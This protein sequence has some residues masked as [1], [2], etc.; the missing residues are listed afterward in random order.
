MKNKEIRFQYR[1]MNQDSTKSKH[2]REFYYSGNN[3]RILATEDNT[4]G[5]ITNEKGNATI[6]TIPTVRINKVS[7]TISWDGTSSGEITYYQANGSGAVPEIED[8]YNR[9]L[10]SL[11]STEQQI[12]GHTLTRDSIIL[13]TTD[14]VDGV[15]KQLDCIWEV[16]DI[17]DG[18]LSLK[19]LYCRNLSFSVNNPIQ[20]LFNYEN[21]IIQKI[22]WIDGNQQTRFINKEHSIVNGDIENLIDI[23]SNTINIVSNFDLNQP[24]IIDNS[25]GGIHTAGM[26]QYSYNLY[27]LNS[28]QTKI[29]PFTELYSLDK[30]E[31][32]GGGGVNDIVG[33]IPIVSI[34]NIDTEYTHIKIYA[35]KYTSLNQIPSISVVYDAALGNQ[36]EVTYYDD[37]N[38]IRTVSLEELIFLGS[39][40]VIP[41]HISSKDN[42]LFSS[43]LKEIA[44]DVDIDCRAFSYKANSTG[45]VWD[46]VIPVGNDVVGS[47]Q[48]FTATNWNNVSEESDAINL[49]YDAQKFQSDGKTIGG[50]GP[51]LKYQLVKNYYSDNEVKELRLYKDDEIYRIAIKFYNKLGQESFPKWIADFKAPATNLSGSYWSLK[52]EL[53]STFIQW[54]SD[55]SNFETEDDRPVGYKII[56]ADRQIG[57]RTI[58]CQG[59]LTGMMARTTDRPED[60]DYWGE[61]TNRVNE[62]DQ[63]TK[64]PEPISR[65]FDSN[66]APFK[67]SS[68]L[69][70]MSFS[71]AGN[72]F[73]PTEIYESVDTGNKRQHSWQYQLMM[74]LYSPE[75]MFNTGLGLGE[76]LQLKIIGL[77]KNTK[78]DYWYKRIVIATQQD[79]LDRRYDDADNMTNDSDIYWLGIFGPSNQDDISDALQVN[80]EYNTFI[81]SNNN[82]LREIYGTP[83]I[84][85]RGQGPTPYNNNSKLKY[86][87]SMTQLA[88]DQGDVNPDAQRAIITMN[89]YGA[90]CLTIVEGNATLELNQRQQLKKLHEKTGIPDTDGCLMAEIRLPYRNIYLGNIYGGNSYEAKQRNS[91]IE[92]GEYRT[93]S[94]ISSTI[95]SPGDTYV[96]T[97]KLARI[98]RTDVSSLDDQVLNHTNT[99]SFKVESTVDLKNRNDKSIFDWDAEFLPKYN[100]FH[101]YNTVY[102]QQPTLIQSTAENFTFKKIKNFD[103]RI[104]ASK[105]KVPG[106]NIDS[107]TDFLVNE[108]MDVDGKYG[109]ITGMVNFRD[110]IYTFQDTGVAKISI[111]PRIQVQ[112]GDGIGIELG[113]GD[114]LYDYN[115]ITT[116]SGTVNK[117]GITATPSGIYY[118]DNFNKSLNRYRGQGIEGLSDSR[119]MHTF[120]ANNSTYSLLK[121]DNPLVQQGVLLS[122]DSINS[123]VFTTLHQGASSF[124]L[125]FNE[126]SDSFTSFYDFRPTMYI[127]KGFKFM[128]IDSDRSK[129][130]Q[131]YKGEYNN[132]Y[133]TTYDTKI[134]LIVNPEDVDSIF[135]NLN[136]KSEMVDPNQSEHP[137]TILNADIHNKTL[138]FFRTYNEYQDTGEKEL[139]LNNNLS[140]KF[141]Q[142]NATIP[143]NQG[144]LDRMRGNWVYLDLIYRPDSNRKLTL[145][146]IKV[147]YTSNP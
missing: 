25:S 38:I 74:Q 80:R 92:I 120:F 19:L 33:M 12:I 79:E 116:S 62:V 28:S 3:L 20:A 61:W 51:Y 130:W 105:T 60:Y 94:Q 93:M 8:Q 109:P 21:D 56:R 77:A 96:Y 115:Y 17:F 147:N 27:R 140:R 110:E 101:D 59:M 138:N 29:S 64:F 137:D 99:I 49:E 125:A 91:Y 6:L 63:L 13:F 122:Y 36:N 66:F 83:E 86:T 144:T 65:N 143:R 37:G 58:L 119:G 103:S 97:Y 76:G 43:N 126:K 95:K 85:E 90:K 129:I 4:T 50:E 131:Q 141:R 108:T 81:K 82:V 67:A 73:T 46:N 133:G 44:F 134:T 68:H 54:L 7:N 22:Y 24:E 39:D 100:E 111:N 135:N 107:W 15:K 104:I 40:P 117:W 146:D 123:D 139:I 69:E 124:T 31:N 32:L 18:S 16:N 26:I 89:S 127:S 34:K 45:N 35:V 78:N 118:Y 5:S 98:A 72:S 87:N 47:A 23:N 57:D 30:G 55:S 142:W 41:Q 71:G 14:G 42:I 70:S 53:K 84:T 52:V 114:V 132:F 136:W 102:S 113:V 11:V 88:S 75:V 106:E 112:A 128:T 145:Y 121:V 1:G 2:P 10:I 48:S 9:G